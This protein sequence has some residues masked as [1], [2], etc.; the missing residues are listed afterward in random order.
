[1]PVTAPLSG[2]ALPGIGAG[3]VSLWSELVSTHR[4]LSTHR[5]T[6]RS[7]LPGSPPDGA[8]FPPRS[9]AGR[10]GVPS[11]G[12][13]RTERGRQVRKDRRMSD[14]VTETDQRVSQVCE[15]SSACVC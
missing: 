6:K 3:A 15:F 11:P 8:E 7:S 12:H 1:M 14:F 4:Q 13:R 5:R 2:M 9:T 10:R